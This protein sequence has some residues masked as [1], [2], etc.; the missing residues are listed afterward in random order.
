MRD[1]MVRVKQISFDGYLNI[2]IVV[3]LLALIGVI[4]AKEARRQPVKA[5]EQ[6]IVQQ[7]PMKTLKFDVYIPELTVT[8]EKSAASAGQSV[9][10][11][12]TRNTTRSNVYPKSQEVASTSVQNV[13][14]YATK[15]IKDPSLQAEVAIPGVLSVDLSVA[16]KLLR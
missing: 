14:P 9:S 8:S 4:M 10:S 2:I 5:L 13:Q 1:V 15:E 3:L 12:E 16:T 6:H 7:Q 11:N